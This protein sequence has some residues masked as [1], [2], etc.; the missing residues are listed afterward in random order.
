[1]KKYFT[2]E[3]YLFGEKPQK[4][5]FQIDVPFVD[6]TNASDEVL[7]NLPNSDMKVSSQEKIEILKK[8]IP[9][10]MIEIIK[11]NYISVEN[12]KKLYQEI[13]DD[14]LSLQDTLVWGKT[15]PTYLELSNTLWLA[16]KCLEGIKSQSYTNRLATQSLIWVENDSIKGMISRQYKYYAS[17]KMFKDD[18]TRKEKA[19]SFVLS[20]LRKD[21]GYKI[22][23]YLG[24]I[25]SIQ[26]YVYKSHG[27]TPGD[28][29]F[30]AALLE[31]GQ[32]NE[33][34]NVL[35]DLGIPTSAIKKI[36]K[37]IP[38]NLETDQQVIQYIK[39]NMNN[40]GNNLDQYEINLINRI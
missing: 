40:L 18:T 3:I 30:F 27:I 5:N 23:K 11:N 35:V 1:M 12:Q 20:F 38:E 32:A 14:Y 2:G 8:D 21:A 4:D 36:S 24:V 26:E 15:V 34:L 33:N 17:K 6:Q 10:E 39:K 16:Y 13:E 7:I 28:Y 29:S 9:F 19:I 22:P 31:N 37:K 25:Q